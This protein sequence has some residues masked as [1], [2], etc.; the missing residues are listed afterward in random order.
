MRP[1][2]ITMSAF[3]PYKDVETID[4][5]KL[6]KSGL[7]LITGDTGA[8]KTTIFDAVT[9]ALYGKASGNLRDGSMMRSKYADNETKTYVELDFE[10]KGKKYT[11]KRNPSYEKLKKN[12]EG[13]TKKS[14]DAELLCHDNG[15]IV[16]GATKVTD[17]IQ[18]II[19]IDYGQFKQIAM[20]AQGDFRELLTADPETRRKI[21]Q[22]IF[23]TELYE[24]ITKKLEKRYKDKQEEVGGLAK[25]FDIYKNNLK[26]DENSVH[27]LALKKARDN[28]MTFESIMELA[29]TLVSEDE[30][31][32]NDLK[33]KSEIVDS[34]IDK[35][36]KSIDK[37]EQYLNVK[38][39]VEKNT[40]AIFKAAADV[41]N[42][43]IQFDAAK[44]A[45]PEIRRITS[46]INVAQANLPEYDKLEDYR[47]KFSKNKKEL[48][49][50]MTLSKNTAEDKQAKTELLDNINRTLDTLDDIESA[51]VTAEHRLEKVMNDKN[52]IDAI[53]EKFS[54]FTDSQ[55]NLKNAQRI[56]LTACRHSID[57]KREHLKA[58]FAYT[59][60]N[61]AEL[62]KIRN[63]LDEINALSQQ[64]T[65]ELNSLEG[66]DVKVSDLTANIK[67]LRDKHKEIKSFDNEISEQEKLLAELKEQQNRY[68]TRQTECDEL[69]EL[70]STGERLQRSNMAGILA[71]KLREGDPC[72]VCG[73]VHH[74]LLAEKSHDA[75][76]DEE[77]DRTK[78]EWELADKLAK[79][80]SKT[81]AEL[82]SKAETNRQHINENGIKLFGEE[83]RNDFSESDIHLLAKRTLEENLRKGTATKTELEE[84]TK[85]SSRR[86]EL[87]ELLENLESDKNRTQKEIDVLTKKTAESESYAR[88][89]ESEF[90]KY[91]SEECRTICEQAGITDI[92]T[93][94]YIPADIHTGITVSE[95][96]L[97]AAERNAKA[98]EESAGTLGKNAAAS[99]RDTEDKRA[100]LR[101]E[102]RKKF[103][104]YNEAD[105]ENLI[106]N[107]KSRV[108]RELISAKAELDRIKKQIENKKKLTAEKLKLESELK[109]IDEEIVNLGSRKAELSTLTAELKK[110]IE[111]LKSKLEFAGKSLAEEN[112]LKLKAESA[113][114]QKEIDKASE[115]LQNAKS[116]LATL[117]GNRQTLE[118]QLKAYD[119]VSEDIESEKEKLAEL[120]AARKDLSDKFIA[121]KGRLA[122]NRNSLEN[123]LKTSEELTKKEKELQM[124][125]TLYETARGRKD[126][127][128]LETYIQI[129]YFDKIIVHA[130]KRLR[131]MSKGQYELIRRG[132]SEDFSETGSG[133]DLDIKD[134]YD[135]SINNTRSVNSLSGGESF[136]ASLSLALGLSDEIMM[137]NG[138]IQL[139]TMFVDEGF[140]SLDDET[141]KKAL[142][143]LNNLTEGNRLVGI[144]SHVTQLK[145]NID[146]QIVVKK[147]RLDGSSIN[148]IS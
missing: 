18:N 74:I 87:K 106:L 142:E 21:Y 84:A 49:R 82:S 107:E 40:A 133:L 113:R 140:G 56:Y 123:M 131:D 94:E 19:G 28:K 25:E 83:Y 120:Q 143:A 17:E 103:G 22:K 134:Y 104:G 115:S 46:E 109:S 130:N 15:R 16:T 66:I 128:T 116:S 75:P 58:A 24:N 38:A 63:K 14:A 4:F 77:L 31:T 55:F 50:T 100:L 79:E 57:S 35:K 80:E 70:Y 132:K 145:E 43:H 125:K 118:N 122:G 99:F 13:T 90:G 65:K 69:L 54:R 119:G 71:E 9:F 60:G 64:Y 78:K 129:Y 147:N 52:E 7:Y 89:T 61:A 98:A 91:I 93:E 42:A 62:E 51:K 126:K 29:A 39:A 124:V 135:T 96:T 101:E 8:G 41:E 148:I 146:K 23:K 26:A 67:I 112:I 136:M 68:L 86:N 10:Y 5:G 92:P 97:K 111:E 144:I 138:G 121:V 3:G 141:L 102:C 1:I 36:K 59:R 11:V 72:P 12:G 45:E 27:F 37:T 95:S 73:N 114:L 53:N 137:S 47:S 127:G 44:L 30:K 108:E 81:A 85:Q 139:D 32:E 117:K 20:I 6:G 105:T 33:E 2:K 76:S 110:Q 34:E 48:E 88:N